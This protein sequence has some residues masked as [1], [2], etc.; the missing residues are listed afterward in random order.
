MALRCFRKK[1]VY[2][3]FLHSHKCFRRKITPNFLAK[4]NKNG[5]HNRSWC[6]SN[7]L[8]STQTIARGETRT[9]VFCLFPHPPPPTP[10]HTENDPSAEAE[11]CWSSVCPADGRAMTSVLSAVPEQR[12]D[13]TPGH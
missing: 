3:Y 7:Q 6:G 11:P 5:T 9:Q 4:E 12:Q 1:K 13:S 8:E 10:T 2:I